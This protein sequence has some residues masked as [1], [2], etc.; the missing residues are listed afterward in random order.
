MITDIST[1]KVYLSS[2]IKA[3]KFEPFWTELEKILSK[4][5]IR[6]SFIDGTRSI[7]CRDYMPI[8]ISEKD[9][10]QFKY[11]P[12]YCLTHKEVGKL[13]IQNEMLYEKPHGIN[14]RQIDLVV[15]GGNIVKSKNKA[16]MTKKVFKENRNRSEKSIVDILIKALKVDDIYFIPIQPYDYT[17]HSDGMV[18]LIDDTTLLINDFSMETPSWIKKFEKAIDQ[19]GI[20]PTIFPYA[21][22]DRKVEND[23]TAEG[24]YINYA[25]IGNL[26][27]FP[28]F[29]IKKDGE[30]MAVIRR[31]FPEPHFHVEPINANLIAEGGG[32]L[33]C[34]TWNIHKPIFETAIDKLVPYAAFG[35]KIMVVHKDDTDENLI[36]T[37]CI[38]LSLDSGEVGKTW[39]R[40]K[41][42]KH[43][44]VYKRI[45]QEQILSYMEQLVKRFTIEQ[46]SDILEA[47][48]NPSKAVMDELV[49]MPPRLNNYNPKK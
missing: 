48:L 4:H 30:A 24:C 3:K 25:Q 21:H 49:H 12:D 1:N 13:T 9:Y 5:Q 27:I 18:R 39:S 17:G 44:E 16:I 47:L 7:W 11:F 23:W 15:D 14:V 46:L 29:G 35:N 10:V 33:N 38:Q 8:Q 42:I 36:D 31:L 41:T 22:S 37:V 32:V 6:P 26:I 43:M 40:A 2:L 28:Q 45:R 34:M 20:E 19:I